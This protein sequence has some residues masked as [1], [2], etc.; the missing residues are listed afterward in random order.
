MARAG[1]WTGLLHGVTRGAGFAR[2][3]LVAR[4][5]SPDDFG[6]FG[7]ALVVL[8]IIERFSNTGLQ[9]ALVQ[10]D[11][12]VREYLD[13]AWTIQVIRGALVC[14]ALVLA[15]S[16]IA[17]LLG[18]GRAAPFIAMTGVTVLLRSLQ[19][20]GMLIYRRELETR[21]QFLH[22]SGGA[23][24]ELVVSIGLAFV[25]RNAWSLILGLVAGKAASL[26][27][28]YV[29]HPYRPHV[30][31]HWQQLRE[32]NSYGRWVF[33]SNMLFFLAYR[34]DNLIVGKFLGAPALGIYML[35]YGI[36]EVVTV[37]IGRFTS[38]VAFPAYSRI[39][40]D[41]ARVRRFFVV[42]LDL[43]AC[44]AFPL[45]TLLALMAGP[46]T[47]VVLG[48]RWSEVAAVLP[49]LALAGALR[50]IIG[51]GTVAFAALGQPALSFRTNLVAVA[52]TYLVMLPLLRIWGLP[53][54]AI[55]VATGLI[56][57]LAPFIVFARRVLGISPAELVRHLVP[58]TALLVIV[59]ATTM[60]ANE[61]LH[62]HSAASLAVVIA[63]ILLIYATGSAVL[64][65]GTR[66]GPVSALMF[67][68]SARNTSVT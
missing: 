50:S 25:L 23:L 28:S 3:V 33:L 52:V 40:S 14:T 32:L 26:A 21:Y 4:I 61:L 53:G 39:Q 12:D 58:G 56:V 49:P 57:S 22:R 47:Q 46:L 51:N 34:G 1:L 18:D 19:N 9:T 68:R 17:G 36:S 29:L 10:T 11:R 64:W 35:A 48:P 8:S 55:A 20:P 38:E 60:G 59:G 6:V 66:R 37:E 13:S 43:V 7:I 63:V 65:V 67:L 27:I 15:A 41:L 54:V 42:V 16:P 24:V 44:V 31:L 30:R 2:N 45:A 5:I 62:E